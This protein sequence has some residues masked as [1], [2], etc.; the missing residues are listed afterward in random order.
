MSTK[1]PKGMHITVEAFK[2]STKTFEESIMYSELFRF[3]LIR[4]LFL[5]RLKVRQ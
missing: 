1:P 5:F 2:K 3:Y 4:E